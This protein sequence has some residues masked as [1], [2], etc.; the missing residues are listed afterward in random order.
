MVYRHRSLKFRGNEVTGWEERME[1]G[2]LD[3]GL[4][5]K[6]GSETEAEPVVEGD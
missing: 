2:K 5:V 3:L 6:V 4:E 1:G